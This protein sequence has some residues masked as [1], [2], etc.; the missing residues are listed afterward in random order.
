MAKNVIKLNKE[1]LIPDDP[2]GLLMQTHFIPLK[3]AGSLKQTYWGDW[4]R[5]VKMTTEDKREVMWPQAKEC[6]LP[7]EAGKTRK[8]FSA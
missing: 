6:L 5:E 7:P 8:R 3:G 1:E 2:S 4:E